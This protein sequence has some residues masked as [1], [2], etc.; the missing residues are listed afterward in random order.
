M[1][2]RALLLFVTVSFA[3][4]NCSDLS[5]QDYTLSSLTG[6]TTYSDVKVGKLPTDFWGTEEA[7][8]AAPTA[9]DVST[10]HRRENFAVLA[11]LGALVA[12]GSSITVGCIMKKRKPRT[13]ARV[14]Q[15]VGV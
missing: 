11:G 10:A 2:R 8:V 14:H 1:S 13:A 5:A 12:L 15:M 7:V 9:T 4:F 3:L 6:E